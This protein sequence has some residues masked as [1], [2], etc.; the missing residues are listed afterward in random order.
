MHMYSNVHSYITRGNCL[1]IYT[2]DYLYIIATYVH[3]LGHICMLTLFAILS[4]VIIHDIIF[5]ALG[6]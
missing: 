2:M 5:A 4:V 3:T 6:F 1:V